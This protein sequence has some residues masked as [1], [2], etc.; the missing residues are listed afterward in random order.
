MP[1]ASVLTEEHSHSTF[2]NILYAKPMLHGL[3]VQ[4]VVLVTDRFHAPRA[5]MIAR[6]LGLD[7]S[8]DCPP[9]QAMRPG[10]RARMYLREMLALPWAWLKLRFF[11][12]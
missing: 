9:A 1:E 8:A 4:N 3:Q 10:L 2:E 6:H 7:A 5:R 12:R 11:S